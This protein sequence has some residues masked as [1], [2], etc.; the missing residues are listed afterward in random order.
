MT[1]ELMYTK[2]NSVKLKAKLT[3]FMSLTDT[4][5]INRLWLEVEALR[6]GIRIGE[7][8]DGYL[9]VGR[10]E[11]TL[12]VPSDALFEKDGITYLVMEVETGL[13]NATETEII[14][15]GKHFKYPGRKGRR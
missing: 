6:D 4:P 12:L 7:Q 8:F 14:K 2:D 3:N 5:N 15:P 11:N 10:S 9:F 1:T 13:A